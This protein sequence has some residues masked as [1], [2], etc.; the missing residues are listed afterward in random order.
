MGTIHVSAEGVVGAPPDTVYGYLADMRVHHPR[1]LPP[2]F[3]DF[4]VESGGVG[5]GTVTRFRVTAGGRSREYHMT[6]SEP[7][8]GRVLKESDTNSSLSTT[9]TVASEGDR[10]R[11]RIATS[12]EGA[13]GIGGFFERMF[14]PK[15]MRSIYADELVRLDRYAQEQ[16]GA[17]P[18]K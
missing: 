7:E 9:F 2:A 1:F 13:G 11:V 14:A 10:S 12:W 8:P 17:S 5:D 3:S 15:A 4:E 6:V 18:A 16:A